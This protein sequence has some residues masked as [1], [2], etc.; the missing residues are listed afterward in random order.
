VFFFFSGHNSLNKNL[1]FFRIEI[2]FLGFFHWKL[3]WV[4]KDY[5]LTPK[6]LNRM[7]ICFSNGK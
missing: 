5:F 2:N 1:F 3:T 4:S 7:V 6:Q